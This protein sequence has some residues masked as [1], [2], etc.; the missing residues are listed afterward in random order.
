M[1][2]VLWVCI[3]AN[4][5]Q[6]IVFEVKFNI[7]IVS[8]RR[9]TLII[10]MKL[11]SLASRLRQTYENKLLKCVTDPVS[12]SCN[13]ERMFPRHKPP[14]MAALILCRL[15]YPVGLCF[16]VASRLLVIIRLP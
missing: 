4:V 11:G 12:T 7:H 15:E 1:I 16:F 6:L 13:I 9:N 3:V 5:T 8:V 10:D 14:D 2:S